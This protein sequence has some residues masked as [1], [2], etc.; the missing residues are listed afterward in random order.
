[1]QIKP[2]ILSGGSGV[3][4][5]PLSRI[6]KA[7]QFIDIFKNKKSLFLDT[8]DRVKSNIFS[9]PIIIANKE[10]RFEVLKYI[11]EYKINT[12][13]LILESSQ[14][15][16]APA[17]AVASF[18]SESDAVLCILP[19]DH[20]IK[21]KKEFNATIIKA[22]KLAEKGHLVSV[23]AICDSANTNFGYILADKKKKVDDGYKIKKFIE[24]PNI[25]K[26]KKLLLEDAFWNTGITVVKN[27]VLKELF[28]KHAKELY[29]LS[30]NSC[31]KAKKDKEFILLSNSPWKKIKSISFDYAIMEKNFDKVIVPINTLWSDLGTFESL[32]KIKNKFGDIFSVDSKNNMTYSDEKLMV[33]SGVEDLIIINTKNAILVSKKGSA[34]NLRKIVEKLRKR[35]REEVF[36]DS[37]EN[38]PWGSFQNIKS[39]KSYKVK[40]LHILP[41][42]KIS[43]QKHL[44]RSEHWVVVEGQ[45]KITKGK[46]T[47]ILST[48][49]STFIKKGQLHRI[50]NV[51]KKDLIIIEVQTGTYLREDDIIRFE[52]KYSR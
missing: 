48:N 38:R 2:V 30:V 24:K 11:K 23:G 14:K 19:S 33:T 49:E 29:N 26:A 10:H 43:L 36:N 18:F 45:A 51:S 7:K 34:K 28:L 35:K 22:S 40:K 47:F 32:S 6:N 12:D 3:R 15:N 25:K 5:W 17:C 37:D 1:M 52:D 9:N 13:K 27:S 46:K 8:L 16:T 50:E 42:E 20:Y 39:E 41:G 31:K 44:K 21:S 4:L